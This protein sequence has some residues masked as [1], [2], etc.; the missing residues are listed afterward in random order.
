MYNKV[1]NWFTST[2][3]NSKMYIYSLDIY[4]W[5]EKGNLVPQM[6]ELKL[7][8]YDII[9]C[10]H[11]RILTYWCRIGDLARIVWEYFIL[12]LG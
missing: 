2:E 11:S 7:Q 8:L 10:I 5:T 4:I 9:N 3:D 6:F 1:N 12:D